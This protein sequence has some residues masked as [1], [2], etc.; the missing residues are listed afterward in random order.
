MKNKLFFAGLYFAI[1]AASLAPLTAWTVA[2]TSGNVTL[3]GRVSCAKCQGIQPLHKGYTRFT[4]ALQSV[5]EGDEVVLV[6]GNDIYRLQGD[7][8]QLL[9]HMEGKVTVTGDLRGRTLD[10][11]TVGPVSKSR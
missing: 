7:K 6:V 4:W 11:Q 3:T 9:K 1:V 5:S 8:D 10:V 2:E